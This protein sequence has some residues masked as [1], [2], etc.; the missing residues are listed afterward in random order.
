MNI[1]PILFVA[2]SFACVFL[3]VYCYTLGAKHGRIVR[4]DGVPHV[5]SPVAVV[6]EAAKNAED[7]KEQRQI[8]EDLA[9]VMEASRES[10]LRAFE[11]QR[12][13]GKKV[14]E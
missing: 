10:M 14:S 12:R 2:Q 3:C 5:K 4:N 1:Y 13:T 6:K 9:G 11:I 7:A 8:G